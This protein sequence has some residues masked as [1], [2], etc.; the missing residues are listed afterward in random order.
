MIDKDNDKKEHDLGS[1]V[2]RNISPTI[3]L[4]SF[5]TILFGG[6]FWLENHYASASELAQLEQRFEIKIRS[7]SLRETNARIW[8]LEERLQKNPDDITAK[9]DLRKLKAG[10]DQIQKELETLQSY[11]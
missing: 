1:W 4:A 9:E 11:K 2:K 5:I 10:K 6:F 8:Q 7:D 3:T